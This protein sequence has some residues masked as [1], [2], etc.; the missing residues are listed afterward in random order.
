MKIDFVYLLPVIAI[1]LAIF[2][3]IFDKVPYYTASIKSR[4]YRK[5]L[6][7]RLTII[8][9]PIATIA[10][11]ALPANELNNLSNALIYCA[12]VLVPAI[13]VHSF[14]TLYFKDQRAYDPGNNV[15]PSTKAIEG[16]NGLAGSGLK[17]QVNNRQESPLYYANLTKHETKNLPVIQ[18][19]DASYSTSIDFEKSSLSLSILTEEG[20]PN[21][22]AAA[23][24]ADAMDSPAELREQLVRVSDQI[25]SHNLGN[26]EYVLSEDEVKSTTFPLMSDVSPSIN[27]ILANVDTNSSQI[28]KM[29]SNKIS[30]L[31]TTLRSDKMKLQKLVIAQQA[32]LVSERKAHDHSRVVARDAIKIM[33]DARNGQKFAEKMVR[34]ERS[35]R[36]RVVQEYKKVAN[37]FNNAMSI[38]ESNKAGN[39]PYS[40]S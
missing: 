1:A 19:T 24:T 28:S 8:V 22:D 13:L 21:E 31:V 12:L 7:L 4:K 17:V 33:K 16:E 5:T 6:L 36:V 27:P 20:A 38:I 14:L 10:A 32:S 26:V 18:L 11:I 40:S 2:Y 23:L 39:E 9:I 35:K 3:P 30:E 34:L 25:D 29:S 37:A 15:S